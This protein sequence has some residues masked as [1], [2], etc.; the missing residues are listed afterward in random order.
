VPAF[1]ARVGVN[2]P[3]ICWQLHFQSRGASSHWLAGVPSPT[4]LHFGL[5]LTYSLSGRDEEARAEAGEV[6]RT[7]PQFSVESYAKK[8]PFNN[9]TALDRWIEALRKAGL[10]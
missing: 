8:M 7:N 4:S 5:A 6:P 10:K 1:G 2:V 3:V 9:Q